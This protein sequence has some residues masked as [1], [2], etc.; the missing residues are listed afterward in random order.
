MRRTAMATLG[1]A[2]LLSMLV[3][4]TGAVEARSASSATLVKVAFNNKLKKPI[5][6]DGKGWTLYMFTADSPT[7]SNCT[8]QIIPGCAKVWPPLRAQGAPVAGK[9]IIASKLGR[10]KRSDGRTQVTYNGHPLYYFRGAGADKKPGDVKG[11]GFSRL[12]YVLS[13]KGTP[14]RR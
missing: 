6:V 3:I 7:T 4:C 9:G 1:W 12:W 13:P 2:L 11:Q 14:I 5:V 10:L 8:E